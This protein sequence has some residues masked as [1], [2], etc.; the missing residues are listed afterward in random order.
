MA[1]LALGA[2]LIGAGVMGGTA[3]AAGPADAPGDQVQLQIHD[4]GTCDGSGGLGDG[5]C[6]GSGPAGS[7]A[8]GGAGSGAGDQDQAR[9]GSCG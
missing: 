9:D 5:T 8:G 7:G 4:P 2:G 1:A 6:D 3:V